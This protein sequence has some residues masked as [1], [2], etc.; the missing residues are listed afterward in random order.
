MIKQLILVVL[1]ISAVLAMVAS[2]KPGS[3]R[4]ERAVVI[5]APPE[6]VFALI[7]DFR[8]VS[9]WSPL[10]SLDPSMARSIGG[11]TSGKGAVYEWRG[12]L[13]AG[14][15]RAEIVESRPPT[16]ILMRVDL[17][18]PISVSGTVEY[19]LAVQPDSS[20]KVTWSMYGPSPF[21]SKVVQVFLT[22]DEV[23]GSNLESGLKRMKVAAER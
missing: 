20:T 11:A 12:N 3:F 5:N 9:V 6:K 18:K 2:R 22:M 10:D 19:V 15:G 14:A 21:A 13:Q 1:A 16:Q 23:L 7:N 4:V 17:L 8:R